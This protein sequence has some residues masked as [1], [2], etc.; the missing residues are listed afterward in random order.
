MLFGRKK[1][2]FFAEEDEEETPQ[3]KELLEYLTSLPEAE[4]DD[5]R[6]LSAEDEE[7]ETADEEGDTMTADANNLAEYIRLRTKAVQLTPKAELEKEIDHLQDLLTA[8]EEDERC[9][10]IVFV[11][12][13]ADI[14]Y[15]SD[16]YMSNNY[17]MIASLVDEKDLPNT[18]VKMVRFNAKTYPSPTP[19]SYFERSP[20]LAAMPQ[21][22]RAIEVLG[23]NDDFNDIQ[24]LTNNIGERFLY[25]TKFMSMKYARAL[26]KVDE[27]TD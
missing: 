19:L 7:I 18:I 21:I 10:D 20:Y 15:Y 22:E 3:K 2:G 13:N 17:A 9:H 1:P 16:Q 25:S 26:A 12:G 4:Q 24:V 6:E 8:M 11:T 23:R 27:Y 5:F 14:Y